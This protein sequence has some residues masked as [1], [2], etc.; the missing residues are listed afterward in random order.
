M[1]E[2][3]V[4]YKVKNT[5]RLK[6]KAG[7]ARQLTSFTLDLAREFRSCDA[8]LG[9]HR[10]QAMESL[11][12]ICSMAKQDVLTKQELTEWRWLSAIHMYHYA[13]CNFSV[14][15]KF[16]YFLHLPEQMERGGVARQGSWG[17]HV[18]P[19]F[20]ASVLR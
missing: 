2:S 3:H 12:K 17:K 7:Q 4:Y 13:H 1:W 6:A 15:P 16:H 9:E 18:L 14:V 10:F 19:Y 5:L 11:A 8:E 20:V